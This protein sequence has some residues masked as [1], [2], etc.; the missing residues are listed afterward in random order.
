MISIIHYPLSIVQKPRYPRVCKS[1]INLDK[2][3]KD[4]IFIRTFS[5]LLLLMFSVTLLTTTDSTAVYSC[6]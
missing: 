2:Q 5:W 3:C 4:D 1:K 6:R